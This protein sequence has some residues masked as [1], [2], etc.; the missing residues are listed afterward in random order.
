MEV[1]ELT[2]ICCPLGCPLTVRLNGD[3]IEV[4]GNSC[5]RGAEYGK[6]EVL[7]PTRVVTSS[8]HVTGGDMEMVSV[9][10]KQD[11]PK[12]RI[13]A[14]MEEIRKARVSAP[15]SIGDVI[16]P[17]CA[18]TGVPVVATRNIKKV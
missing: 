9:K 18:G 1:K 14:C 17:D 7:N 3:Q 5:G 8:V 6:K 13:F 15:V 4:T 10:T 11:I 12:N 2:C 16:I